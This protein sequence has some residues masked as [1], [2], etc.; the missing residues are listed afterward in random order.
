MTLH[1]NKGRDHMDI[2]SGS[3]EKAIYRVK[4]YSN[5][6]DPA[7]FSGIFF[8]LLGSIFAAIGIILAAETTKR[9]D[10]KLDDSVYNLYIFAS[11]GVFF[12]I[13]GIT[14]LFNFINQYCTKRHVRKVGYKIDAPITSVN[15]KNNISFN[16]RHPYVIVCQ[17]LD[18]ITATLESC[19]SEL[20]MDDPSPA[21]SAS[22]ITN[23]PVYI[24]RNNPNVY[25]MDTSMI[26]Y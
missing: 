5:F 23:M 21:L 26:E 19:E 24:D 2:Y 7:L 14:F 3:N 22:G 1:I 6:L 25:Y 12:A 11:F 20:F 17:W 9:L 13:I 8:T 4:K 16:E 15:I 18:S 10:G